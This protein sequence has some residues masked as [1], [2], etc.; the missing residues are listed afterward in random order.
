MTFL[1]Q[2]TSK[3]SGLC[4]DVEHPNTIDISNPAWIQEC[5][6][7]TTLRYEFSV[8]KWTTLTPATSRFFPP[9][10][11]HEVDIE[12]SDAELQSV[13]LCPFRF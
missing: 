13:P 10:P 3:Q 1:H 11:E 2:K 4:F 12:Q 9:Q 5:Q 8:E 6:K 7:S